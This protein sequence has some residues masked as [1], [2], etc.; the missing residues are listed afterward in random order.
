[1]NGPEI[2]IY[3]VLLINKSKTLMA[4]YREFEYGSPVK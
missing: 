3:T 2:P 1:M 4:L